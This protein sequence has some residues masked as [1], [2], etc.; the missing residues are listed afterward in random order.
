MY[1]ATY[2]LIIGHRLAEAD[3]IKEFSVERNE[4]GEKQRVCF[5]HR[6]WEILGHFLLNHLA[7]SIRS[8]PIELGIGASR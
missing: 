3:S 1:L 2:R 8:D 4:L 5:A 6:G 7:H